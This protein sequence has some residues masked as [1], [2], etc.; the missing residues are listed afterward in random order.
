[1]LH[2][3]CAS[4]GYARGVSFSLQVPE[5]SAQLSSTLAAQL[6]ILLRRLV[7]VTLPEPKEP[8]G[9][10]FQTLGLGSPE[11]PFFVPMDYL[12]VGGGTSGR[13]A[14]GTGRSFQEL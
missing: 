3:R 10:G 12:R 6:A 7:E 9:L 2:G 4:C 11:S 14:E 8:K 13:R 5:V 1:R